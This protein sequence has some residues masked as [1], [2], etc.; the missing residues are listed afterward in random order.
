[1][2]ILVLFFSN[3]II[4]PTGPTGIFN[5][6]IKDNSIFIAATSSPA[7]IEDRIEKLEKDTFLIKEYIDINAD[8]V[9]SISSINREITIIKKT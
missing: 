8:Y 5:E 4:G 9:L 3:F 6:V 2:V 7:D 1:V